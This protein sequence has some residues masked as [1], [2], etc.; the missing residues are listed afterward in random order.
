MNAS[1]QGQRDLQLMARQALD[2]SPEYIE[3]IC[4]LFDR[5]SQ[6]LRTGADQ[7][8]M[9]ALA[10]AADDLNQF[11]LLVDMVAGIAHSDD[12]APFKQQL[13]GCVRG[14]EAALGADDLVG[15][16]DGIEQGLLPLLPRWGAVADGLAAE[17]DAA[18]V[19]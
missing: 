4:N 13:D 11:I 16:S 17:I 1:A 10:R 6:H 5:C 9:R 8:G 3:H 14:L 12:V 2:D 15:V 19:A 7:E 18:L